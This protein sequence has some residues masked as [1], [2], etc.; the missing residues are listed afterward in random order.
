MREQ[1]GAWTLQSPRSRSARYVLLHCQGIVAHPTRDDRVRRWL[2]DQKKGPEKVTEHL[3][4]RQECAEYLRLSD[5]Q[6]C[7]DHMQSH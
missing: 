4:A 5:S 6:F 1:S 7:A 2:A 3:V